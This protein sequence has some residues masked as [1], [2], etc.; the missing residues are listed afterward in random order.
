L[1]QGA[2]F[3]DY[4]RIGRP[5]RC[6]TRQAPVVASSNQQPMAYRLA[7]SRDDEDLADELRPELVWWYLSNQP[8]T[9]PGG[10]LHDFDAPTYVAEVG[11]Q[12]CDPGHTLFYVSHRFLVQLHCC[13]PHPFDWRAGCAWCR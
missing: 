2:K 7:D 5:D 11:S 3:D 6:N 1:F 4:G 13:W 8:A 9:L 12:R 10:S